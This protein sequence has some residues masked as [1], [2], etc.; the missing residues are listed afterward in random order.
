MEHD[1]CVSNFKFV[2]SFNYKTALTSSSFLLSGW[3]W[4]T[5]EKRNGGKVPPTATESLCQNEKWKMMEKGRDLCLMRNMNSSKK[6]IWETWNMVIA[7]AG[8]RDD[9]K[10]F[11]FFFFFFYLNNA[12]TVTNHTTCFCGELWLVRGREKL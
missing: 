7:D 4:E 3:I 8:E 11:F 1:P 10:I 12:K 6:K 9:I 2:S 5:T